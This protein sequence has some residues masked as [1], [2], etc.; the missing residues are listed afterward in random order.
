MQRINV[1]VFTFDI[2]MTIHKLEYAA[3]PVSKQVYLH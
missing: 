1:N 3:F 2:L